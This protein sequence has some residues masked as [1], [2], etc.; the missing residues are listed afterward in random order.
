MQEA[1]QTVGGGIGTYPRAADSGRGA[2]Q[3]AILLHVPKA[4]GAHDGSGDH[5]QGSCEMS[6]SPFCKLHAKS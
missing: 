2:A 5:L 3:P 1:Q 4:S 6:E